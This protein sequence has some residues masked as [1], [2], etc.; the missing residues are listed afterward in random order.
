MWNRAHT[1]R[2]SLWLGIGLLTFTGVAAA[3]SKATV[4]TSACQLA[5]LSSTS[6]SPVTV[7]LSGV[8]A[9]DPRHGVAFLDAHCRG[10]RVAFRFAN[11]L[12]PTSEAGR[13]Q[14]AIT[15]RSTDMSLR[16]FRVDD[17]SGTLDPSAGEH[18]MLVV[19]HVDRFEKLSGWPAGFTS[20]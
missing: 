11:H 3:T 4:Q 20:P 18:G 19:D 8:A 13:F 14:G 12:T 7:S 10:Q 6:N 1:M 9:R 16:L 17:A 2:R 15:P 5:K